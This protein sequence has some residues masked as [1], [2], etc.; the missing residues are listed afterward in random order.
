M[1]ILWYFGLLII[2]TSVSCLKYFD[3]ISDG[4]TSQ[5]NENFPSGS[6]I[7]IKKTCMENDCN[8]FS[9]KTNDN[10]YIVSDNWNGNIVANVGS[11]IYSAAPT[12]KIGS[13]SSNETCSAV[14][15]VRSDGKRFLCCPKYKCG[16]NCDIDNFQEF[17]YSD[18]HYYD[19]GYYQKPEYFVTECKEDCISNARCNSLV[20][21]LN[22][23]SMQWVC[24][25][26]TATP[27]DQALIHQPDT[28]YYLNCTVFY[29]TRLCE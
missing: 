15:Y 14:P 11:Y 9:C 26:K 1:K 3:I 10:C 17:P 6:F 18:I 22:Q 25:T 23:H 21:Y 12:C 27:L 2:I 16:E 4:Y 13:C 8:V 19:I 5:V 29:R 28:T 7:E 20:F 24:Y